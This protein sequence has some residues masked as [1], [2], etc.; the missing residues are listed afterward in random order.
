MVKVN[1]GKR[2]RLQEIRATRGQTAGETWKAYECLT[3]SPVAIDSHYLSIP[4]RTL[5]ISRDHNPY[6]AGLKCSLSPA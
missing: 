3:Q 5:S 6:P 2:S 4:E 1:L